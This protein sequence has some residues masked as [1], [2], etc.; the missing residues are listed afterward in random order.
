MIG[1]V[2]QSVFMPVKEFHKGGE[3]LRAESI[4]FELGGKG[5][6]QAIA[7]ARYGAS[8]AFLGAVGE[9][10]ADS[11]NRFLSEEGIGSHIAVKDEPSPYAV[12]LTDANGSNRVTVYSGAALC[13]RDVDG[14]AEAVASADVLLLSNE[15]PE[16]VNIAAARIAR[17]SGTAVILNPA[18]QRALSGE[19]SELVDLFTPN[20]YEREGIPELSNVI[21]TLGSEGCLHCESGE[22]IAA[23]KVKAV[24]TTGAGDTFNGVLAACIGEGREI[25]EAMKI[26]GT[27]ATLSVTKRY[28]IDSIPTREE[29][30]RFTDGGQ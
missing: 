11:V 24:D 28:V 19:L 23:A 27:A 6:N 9:D 21:V 26:A 13:P 1:L 22:R 16:G 10:L 17:M 25:R 7:A 5:F 14:F 18:P 12:I 3:T 2:G 4:R 20:E 15:V 29:I 8:V 30:E